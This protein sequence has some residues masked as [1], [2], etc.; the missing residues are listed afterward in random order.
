ML[1]P[2]DMDLS[3]TKLSE[4]RLGA[5]ADT[6]TLGIHCAYHGRSYIRSCIHTYI[7]ARDVLNICPAVRD[8][9]L[10]KAPF[11]GQ[12]CM[13]ALLRSHGTIRRTVGA[14]LGITVSY[15]GL[16]HRNNRNYEE[17]EKLMQ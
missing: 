12:V 2:A 1:R 5:S 3:V 11:Q 8:A 4:L 6:K 15:C 7:S 16:L 13:D 14:R 10:I 17:F 9:K